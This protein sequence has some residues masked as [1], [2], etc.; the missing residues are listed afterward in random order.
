MSRSN[1]KNIRIFKINDTIYT[2]FHT[3]KANYAK[4]MF[5]DGSHVRELTP[6][7]GI[8]TQDNDRKDRDRVFSPALLRKG[9]KSPSLFESFHEENGE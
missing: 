2:N 9:K 8:L 1:V 7:R 3:Q 5:V 6:N 4:K